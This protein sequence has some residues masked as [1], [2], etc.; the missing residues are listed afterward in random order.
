M[1]HSNSNQYELATRVVHGVHQKNP[2]G[3][4]TVPIY[5]T[6]TFVFD[7]AAQGGDR[8]AGKDD[9]F[10]YTRLGNPTTRRL[11]E[12]VAMLEC[13]E[14]CVAFSSGMGAISGTVLT[15]LKAGDHL[16][17]DRTLY[18]CTFALFSEKLPEFGIDVE[19]ADFSDIE[20]VKSALR[21]DTRMVYF[22]TPANPNMKIIDIEAVSKNAHAA[23]PDCLVIVDNTFATPMLTRPLEH[24]TDIVVHS[25]TKYLNGHGDVIAGF[26]ISSHTLASTVRS[27]G[28]KDVTGS[29]LG[30]QEAYLLL[31]GLKTLKI[32]MDVICENAQKVA[33][34]LKESPHVEVVYFPGLPDHPGHDIAKKQMQAF[35][36]MISFEV[37][38][39]QIAEKMLDNL[40]LCVLAV[41]LGDCET[42]IQ[43]PASMT[44]SVYTAEEIRAAGFSERLVRLSL[45]LEDPKDIIADLSQALEKAVR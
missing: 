22:E 8:F 14:E 26:S 13:G 29:V 34:F 18:G 7:N 40:K 30:P 39:A 33:A 1:S 31:R 4:L 16:L 9:G 24:G 44:H 23:S 25:A 32:R 28:L 42:L 45:G 41:S 19:F 37:K 11:E 12:N 20:Q 15:F 43:H 17:A 6:S 27:V 3:A 2:Q 10:I 36:G 35:G 38:S 5:Q 21:P